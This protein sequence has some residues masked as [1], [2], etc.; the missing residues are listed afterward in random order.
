MAQVLV[1]VDITQ[2]SIL[3]SQQAVP[4]KPLPIRHEGFS[5]AG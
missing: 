3:S 1:E 5:I 4:V 2:Y